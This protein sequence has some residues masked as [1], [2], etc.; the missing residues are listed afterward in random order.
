MIINNIAVHIIGAAI[1]AHFEVLKDVF[2]V[3]Q[4]VSF[5]MRKILELTKNLDFLICVVSIM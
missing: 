2:G 4:N 3:L 1:R 5:I